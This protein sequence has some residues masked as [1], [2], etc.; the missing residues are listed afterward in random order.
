MSRR[1]DPRAD[2]RSAATPSALDPMADAAKA[3]AAAAAAAYLSAAKAAIDVE[4]G[5][6]Y[7]AEHPELVAAFMQAAAIEAATNGGRIAVREICEALVA[8]KPRLF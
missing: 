3:P 6:G 4:F 2:G 8:L 7:A 5:D 1:L